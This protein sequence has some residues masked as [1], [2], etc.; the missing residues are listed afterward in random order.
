MQINR[1]I[2]IGLEYSISKNCVTV[3]SIG[4]CEDVD[5]VIPEFIEGKTVVAIADNAF[6]RNS[7]IKSVTLPQSLSFIGKSAFAWCRN[8][9]RVDAPCVIEICDKA[10]MGCDSL[11]DIGLSSKLR[12]IGDKTFAFCPSLTS[13]SMPNGIIR[14]GAS[15]FEGCR[16]LKTVSLPQNLKIIANST[17]YACTALERVI[18]PQALAYVDELAFAYCIALE[19]PVI[20]EKTVINRDAFFE[21]GSR[22]IS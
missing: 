21:C 2:S 12:C 10:F 19:Y 22:K 6:T 7:D 8:L 1:M 13:A 18:M 5:I 3:C 9:E 20:P 11:T 15:V 16:N 14:M 4:S 17:F